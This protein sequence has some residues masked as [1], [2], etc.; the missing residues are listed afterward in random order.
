MP[1]PRRTEV[2]RDL[3]CH[4]DRRNERHE[5][6]CQNEHEFPEFTN[7]SYSRMLANKI[8]YYA[9]ILVLRQPIINVSFSQHAGF[10]FNHS[11]SNV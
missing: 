3:T 5:Q 1:C 10:L 9:F 4:S 11:L 8:P 7:T 2:D 6:C